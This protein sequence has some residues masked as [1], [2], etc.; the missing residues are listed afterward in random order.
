[1]TVESKDLD[2]FISLLTEVIESLGGVVPSEKRQ[3]ESQALLEKML[4]HA[5]TMRLLYNRPHT[6]PLKVQG[7][8]V[9][10]FPSAM[11]LSRALL[12]TYLTLH[13][14]FL[15]PKSPDEFDFSYYLWRIR[16]LLALQEFESL[17]DETEMKYQAFM[18]Q[19]E[20]FRAGLE[21]TERFKTLTLGQQNAARSIGKDQS[22][23]PRD[24]KAAGVGPKTFKRF[25]DFSSGYVHTDGQAANQIR[26]AK[27]HEDQRAMFGM[28]LQIAAMCLARTIAELSNLYLECRAA[29]DASPQGKNMAEHFS[30]LA[31]QIEDEDLRE[32]VRQKLREKEGCDEN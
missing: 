10:D 32:Q 17:S 4:Q 25:F 3:A 23:P 16:G 12:D 13:E 11:V 18:K 20:F 14:V 29:C 9:Y 26:T 19:L 15:A 8:T 7:L 1:M 24:Y 28:P 27:S 22:V 6:L 30:R 21:G 31:M 5:L 2:R